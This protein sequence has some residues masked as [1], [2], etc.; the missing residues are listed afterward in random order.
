MDELSSATPHFSCTN[1]SVQ[2]SPPKADFNYS[3]NVG[4][5]FDDH[6]I[7]LTISNCASAWCICYIKRVLTG[8]GPV[9]PD[10][11]PQQFSPFISFGFN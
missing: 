1:I 9:K 2:A 8:S 6:S 5:Y 10:D 4:C 7:A 11:L 3:H